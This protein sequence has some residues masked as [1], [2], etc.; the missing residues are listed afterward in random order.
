M[1]KHKKYKK[2]FDKKYIFWVA[3]ILILFLGSLGI[4]YRI[5]PALFA[6]LSFYLDLANPSVK[7]VQVQ[8][9]LRKEQVADLLSTRLGWDE[10]KKQD[11]LK[12]HLAYNTA[13][14]EGMYFPKTYLVNESEDPTK[15]SAEMFEEFSSEVGELEENVVNKIT[16]RKTALI[17]ASI[18]QREAAGKHDMRLISGIIWNRIRNG[19]KLQLDATLQYAKGNRVEGWWKQVRPEDKKIVSDYNTYLYKGLPTGAISNPGLDAI[20]AAYNPLPTECMFYL[21]DRNRKI[22]CSKTYEGHRRN[23]NLYY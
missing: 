2:K 13:D 14:A 10:T 18:I 7:L 8:E 6:K 22:H 21:H 20:W 12:L 16:D 9:G 19:M 17:I 15:V 11:F 5:D 3:G 4:Y 1:K 23:I